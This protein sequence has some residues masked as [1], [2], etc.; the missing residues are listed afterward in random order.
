MDWIFFLKLAILLEGALAIGFGLATIR[1]YWDHYRKN[2]DVQSLHLLIIRSDHLLLLIFVELVTL[3]LA[4]HR[5]EVLLP[6]L[7]L[8]GFGAWGMWQLTVT[9]DP[10]R[11][12]AR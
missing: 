8:L 12:R 5:L 4:G 10:L 3:L 7:V 2:N 9:S 1:S 6:L 11:K